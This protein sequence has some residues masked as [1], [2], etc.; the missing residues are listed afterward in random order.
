MLDP[1]AIFLGNAIKE[2]GLTPIPLV[3]T[4]HEVTFT[5]GLA[6]VTTHRLFRNSESANIE[7][8]LTF[9]VPVHATLFELTAEIEGRELHA[10]AQARSQAREVY[11]EAVT[12][13]KSAVLHEELLKGIHMIS[14]ANI[15]PGGEIK[16]TTKWAMPLS[17]TAGRA[18]LRIPQT[19]GDV[20]GRSGLYDADDLLT[21]GPAQ[22]VLVSIKSDGQ[23]EVVGAQLVDGRAAVSSADPIDLV[24]SLWEP[25]QISGHEAGGHSV[26]LMLTPQSGG[27]T[28]L[29]VAVL[30]DHSGSMAERAGSRSSFSAHDAARNGIITLANELAAGDNVDLWEFDTQCRRVGVTKDEASDLPAASERLAYLAA[31]LSPPRGG[32]EIGGALEAVVRSSTSKD[33]LLLTDGLSHELNIEKLARC[34]RRIS[35]V[36]IGADSLEARIGHLAALTGGDLFIATAEDLVEVMKAAIDAL[37]RPAISLPTVTDLPD[38][39][40]WVRNNVVIRANWAKA[41]DHRAPSEISKASRAV[42]A[43]LVVNCAVSEF[44][45][46]YAASEGIV[47]HLT[48]LVLVDGVGTAQAELPTMRKIALPS[49]PSVNNMHMSAMYESRVPFELA[50]SP[51]D[52]DI[53]ADLSA[54]IDYLPSSPPM[55]ERPIRSARKALSQAPSA[56]LDPLQIVRLIDWGDNPE[57]LTRGDF[58]RLHHEV[59]QFIDEL[60]GSSQLRSLS[61]RY[62][63]PPKVV[64]IAIMAKFASD[65]DQRAGRIWYAIFKRICEDL[66]DRA[67]LELMK[68]L[69][70][71]IGETNGRLSDLVGQLAHSVDGELGE[72]VM[73]VASKAQTRWQAIIRELAD[74]AENRLEGIIRARIAQAEQDFLQAINDLVD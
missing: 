39:L 69:E 44:A 59:Q 15:Q 56:R 40:V 14:V 16:V 34:G 46:Q 43:S 58:S 52:S 4:D 30:V 22:P 3:S 66:T 55:R 13:G 64:A 35:V 72:V 5:A 18:T 62:K 57:L 38:E 1:L 31:Q 33:V 11:E 7:A 53:F 21:G 20:Y 24:G 74:E 60:T 42:A 23:V 6:V 17:V 61:G 26:S 49:T 36:L 73:E 2:R 51:A 63:M 37:R 29:D 45:A 8:V 48:S 71:F 25:I 68:P 41:S 47:S 19:L 50:S 70:F 10:K 9:P 65:E 27:E 54:S 28:A 67:R 12:R 32:T